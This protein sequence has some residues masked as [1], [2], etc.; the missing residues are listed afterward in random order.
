[1]YFSL[2]NKSTQIIARQFAQLRKCF[3]W[4]SNYSSCQ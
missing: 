1:M 3:S 2:K 4:A